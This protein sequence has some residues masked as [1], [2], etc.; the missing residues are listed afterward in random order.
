MRSLR[1]TIALVTLFAVGNLQAATPAKEPAAGQPPA[2]D[3]NVTIATVNGKPYSVELFRVFYAQRLQA[4]QAQDSPEFQTRTLDEFM[5]L[6]VAAQEAGKRKLTERDDVKAALELQRLQ[7]LSNV[8][9]Q[10]MARDEK[11]SDDE[12][13]KAYDEFVAKTKRTQYKAR[14]ILVKTKDEAEKLIKQLGK[15]A[16][17]SKLA[18]DNSMAPNAKN[19][20]E[21]GWVVAD[22]IP[23][24]LSEALA[25]LKPNTY[26]KEPVRTQF[27]WHVIDLEDTRTAEPPSLEDLK[28][29]LTAFLQRQ[30]AT[31]ELIKL[32][33]NAMVELNPDIVKTKP[34]TEPEKKATPKSK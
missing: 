8:T 1:S 7:V 31:E 12:I 2:V 16:D 19:G 5:T 28:P 3:G 34:G 21:L 22:Q 23:K 13:K 24:P 4:A 32:R 25:K 15:G 11:V 27:G 9:L 29:Q 30:K 17:F 10:A 18:R 26:A 6:V 20:G 14:H 33:D